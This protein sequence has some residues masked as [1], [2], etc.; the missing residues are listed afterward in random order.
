MKTA[1]VVGHV[2]F[3]DLGSYREVLAD[4]GYEIR[5]LEA[6]ITPLDTPEARDAD[7]L[8]VLGGPIGAYE[9]ERYPFLAEERALIEHR[10][11]AR[12]PVLGVCLGAQLLALAAGGRVYAGGTKEIGWGPVRLTAEGERSP[13]AA[14]GDAHVLHWHGD[15]FDLPEGA[16]LLA[17]TAAYAHQA[18]A[19]GD[20]ALALQFHLEAGRAIERWSIGHTLELALAGIDLDVLRRQTAEHY[21]R[22]RAAAIEVLTAWLE[23]CESAQRSA[24]A[25]VLGLRGA[26]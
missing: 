17:S 9:V 18:F 13:L 12:K 26:G 4:R 24:E 15:T 23:R 6:G 2:C 7:L 21:P 11:T 3:E 16:V 25:N 20:H 22:V 8:V 19:L 1:V 5:G 10:L 14:I